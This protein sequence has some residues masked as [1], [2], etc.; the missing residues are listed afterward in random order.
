M[1]CWPCLSCPAFLF[2]FSSFV[3]R[4]VV[5]CLCS[6]FHVPLLLLSKP[7]YLVKVKPCVV[8]LGTSRPNVVCDGLVSLK[9]PLP[10]ER[11]RV[12]GVLINDRRFAVI[13]TAHAVMLQVEG[14][15]DFQ[16]GDLIECYKMD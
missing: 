11:K 3:P 10:L 1:F 2:F 8:L 4:F 15:E 7:W 16:E 9:L 13:R 14:F 5:R 6:F 12:F